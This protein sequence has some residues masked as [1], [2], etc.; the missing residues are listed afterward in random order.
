MR[1]GSK[2]GGNVP[3][4]EKYVEALRVLVKR[5]DQVAEVLA[6]ENW[7]QLLVLLDDRQ[8]LMAQ[9]D[10]LTDAVSSLSDEDRVIAVALLDRV[11]AQDQIV[12]E[13]LTTAMRSTEAE[14]AGTRLSRLTVSAYRKSFRSDGGAPG[15]RFFD[16]QR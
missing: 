4:P 14:L 6:V 11:M 10:S 16:R 8:A 13:R 1:A 9:I 5:M 2:R 3:D 7:D 12:M 15:S